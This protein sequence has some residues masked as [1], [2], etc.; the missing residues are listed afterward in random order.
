MFCIQGGAVFCI[1]AVE[2]PFLVSLQ[3]LQSQIVMSQKYLQIAVV[4]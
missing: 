4:V 3:C 1:H 2:T